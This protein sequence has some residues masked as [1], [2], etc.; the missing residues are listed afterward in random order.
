MS[1]LGE[2]KPFLAFPKRQSSIESEAMSLF[3][4]TL[5]VGLTLFF[6][7]LLL[8]SERPL[9]RSMLKSLPRSPLA[10]YVF[11]GSASLWFLH[12][13]WHLPEA[14]FGEYH[15]ALTLLFSAVAILSFFYVPDFLAVRGLAGLVLLSASPLLD[16]A[17]GLYAYPQ[18]LFLV[19]LIFLA[20]S[21]ALWLGAQ[22][23][24]LRDWIEWLQIKSS[25]SKAAGS[26]G[27][28]YGLLLIATLF[29]Y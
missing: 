8:F 29:T 10:T 19:T 15:V 12:R 7:G 5:L 4:S 16:S 21:L 2:G 22:P 13:V 20:I 11:F 6:A 27:M 24:K 3:W 14:D 1:P 17:Y 25:R 9:V 26:L 18:R 28:A 23:Y